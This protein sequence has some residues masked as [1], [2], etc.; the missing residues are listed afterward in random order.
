[1]NLFIEKRSNIQ[2]LLSFSSQN[3]LKCWNWIIKAILLWQHFW[4][5]VWYA[6]AGKLSFLDLQMVFVQYNVPAQALSFKLCLCGHF[7]YTQYSALI[8]LFRKISNNENY[9]CSL[10]WSRRKLIIS[11]QHKSFTYEFQTYYQSFFLYFHIHNNTNHFFYIFI[12]IHMHWMPN[13]N[14]IILRPI[15]KL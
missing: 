10:Y 6:M 4:S 9:A 2:D 8:R 14:R 13:Q 15:M 7:S 1:M 12:F 5:Q 11:G 3:S